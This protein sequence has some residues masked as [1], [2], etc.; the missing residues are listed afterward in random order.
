MKLQ[1]K[2]SPKNNRPHQR[3]ARTPRIHIKIRDGRFQLM[4]LGAW[5]SYWRD[6]YHLMLI[7]PWFGFL[8]LVGLS[9]ILTN[10]LF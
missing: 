3:F 10:A 2:R 4:G 1:S 5:Y 7:I 9:Y 8:S 6:P